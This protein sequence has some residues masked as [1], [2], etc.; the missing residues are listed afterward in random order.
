[1]SSTQK[2]GVL[3]LAAGLGTRMRS[4]KP[5]MLHTLFSQPL[6]YYPIDLALNLN[7]AQIIPII[8]DSIIKSDVLTKYSNYKNL[9]SPCIQEEPLG[10][11]HAV[12]C[13][14]QHIS[15]DIKTVFI[16]CGDIPAFSSQTAKDFLKN[17]VDSNATLSVL[18]AS[19]PNPFGFGRIIKNDKGDFIK[20]VEQKD[21]NPQEKTTNEVNSGIYCID[22]N[23]LRK[24]INQLSNNNSQTEFYL[25]D[26]IE[27]AFKQGLTPTTFKIEDHMEI[28]G[29]NTLEQLATIQRHMQN[30]IL[31]NF[32]DNGVRII[33][34]FTTYISPEVSISP[35]VTIHP[36]THIHG[37][38]IISEGAIIGPNVSLENIKIA[39]N[40]VISTQKAINISS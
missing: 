27:I 32:M 30:K 2:I 19:L 22:I 25:T 29:V 5:K 3:I 6:L 24:S 11:G 16:L 13:G 7:P 21:A 14:L 35:D 4:K 40:E 37:K 9:I 10:T 23:F 36:C 1:M 26:I 38:T 8:S 15:P 17:H 31:S 18:T 34:P 33:D 39:K 28:F 12:Q 20:I